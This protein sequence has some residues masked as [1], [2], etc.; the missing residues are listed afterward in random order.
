MDAIEAKLTNADGAWATRV[1]GDDVWSALVDRAIELLGREL[2]R[3]LTLEPGRMPSWGRGFSVWVRERYTPGPDDVSV[4]AIVDADLVPY[5][6]RVRVWIFYYVGDRRVA[7]VS[8]PTSSPAPTIP[9]SL[10]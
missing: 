5:G 8:T 1:L 4:R 7:P 6:L 10:S 9:A 3:D 2:R